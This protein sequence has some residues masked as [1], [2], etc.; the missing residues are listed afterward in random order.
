MPSLLHIDC[1]PAPGALTR[2]LATDARN[3]WKRKNPSATLVLHDLGRRPVDHVSREFVESFTRPP[4]QWTEEMR[5]ARELALNL[6][7]EFLAADHYLLSM[8]MRILTVPSQFKA[9]VEHI[10]HAG[11]V[12]E[13]TGDG[14]RGLLGGRKVLC[15]TAR[16]G[17][18][19][20]GSS[21]QRFDFL[22]PYLRGLFEFCGIAPEDVQV[23]NV[24]AT[25]G[26]PLARDAAIQDVR[27]AL[28]DHIEVW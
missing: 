22:E 15:I 10:F 13:V 3:S 23:F 20:K 17:D 14:Y 19:R 7:T 28:L 16:G 24:H 11:V 26:D 21:V 8:P 5:A 12:F 25:F 18:Y 9:Y 27:A 6:S 1:S 4:E 2:R